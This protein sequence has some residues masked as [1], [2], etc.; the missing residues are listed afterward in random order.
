MARQK[1][2]Q[3]YPLEVKREAIRLFYEEQQTRAQITQ[4]L[5]IRDR[6]AVKRW[7]QQYRREGEAAWCKPRGR[8][9]HDQTLA[10]ELARVRMENDL[11]KKVLSELRPAMLA[12]RNI[13]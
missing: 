6:G 11:L 13:G 2:R 3:D 5:E 12:K 8:P 1:G 7:V 10:A 4:A 9:R